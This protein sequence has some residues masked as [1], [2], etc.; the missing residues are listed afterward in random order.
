MVDYTENFGLSKLSSGEGL[1]A[2]PGRF[3]STDRD[4]IDQALYSALTHRHTGL[5]SDLTEP[6]TAPDLTLST[7]GGT[8]PAATT[9]RYKYTYVDPEFGETAPSPEAT[10]TTADPLDA[11][12]APTASQQ[13]IGGTLSPGSY[14]Y[15]LTHYQGSDTVETKALSPVQVIVPAGTSTN[16]ITLTLPTIDAEADGFNLYRRSPNQ[17]RYYHLATLPVTATPPTEYVDDGT[18]ADNC[19]R[20]LPPTNTTNSTN[21]ITVAIPGATPAI[22]AGYQ[23]KLYRTYV[24]GDYSDSF[25]VQQDE[26]DLDYLDD[27]DAANAGAPPSVSALGTSPEKVL[28]TGGAEVQGLLPASMVDVNDQATPWS[29]LEGDNLEEVL[30]WIDSNWGVGSGGVAVYEVN[31]ARDDS[32]AEYQATADYIC[33]GTADEVQFQAAVDAVLASLNAPGVGSGADGAIVFNLAPG[34]YVFD[35]SIVMLQSGAPH[36]ASVHMRGPKQE[37]VYYNQGG[38]TYDTLIDV[39]GSSALF[40]IVHNVGP[41]LSFENVQIFTSSTV[42][43]DSVL[44][45]PAAADYYF[46]CIFKRC[47]LDGDLQATTP[48]ITGNMDFKME[49]CEAF[50]ED[51]TFANSTNRWTLAHVRDC[52]VNAYGSAAFFA[53]DGSN[54]PSFGTGFDPSDTYDLFV[55]ENNFFDCSGSTAAAIALSNN[56]ANVRIANNTFYSEAGNEV[57]VQADTCWNLWMTNNQ[58]NFSGVFLDSCQDT[59]IKDNVFLGSYHN[60]I[61]LTDCNTIQASGNIIVDASAAAADTYSG[62]RLDGSS[63]DNRI[64]GNQILARDFQTLY[65]IVINDSSCLSNVVRDN[66]L[67]LNGAATP[68]PLTILDNGTGSILR[69]AVGEISGFPQVIPFAFADMSAQ[70]NIFAYTVE[71]PTLELLGVRA[72]VTTAPT[73]DAVIVDVLVYDP[74]AATPAW[75]S[76]FSGTFPTI[77]TSEEV[78][79]RVVPVTTTLTEGMR[80]RVDITQE[81]SGATAE[82][83]LVNVYG[84]A[85]YT[86]LDPADFS[87]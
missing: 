32:P 42:T 79:D 47:R 70:E 75:A 44:V 68:V 65:G 62:I 21:S 59:H 66:V 28:L 14:Y 86:S 19:D 55:I 48:F 85:Q 35:D 33:D 2:S 84:V 77:A 17:T 16:E 15:V 5:D 41:L 31:M 26:N 34:W 56:A 50:N 12:A 30:S 11:P 7:T 87:E 54:K 82:G 37:G 22:P 46:A 80:L 71:V 73:T 81:D 24:A 4:T 64:T 40:N 29:E 43:D 57:A 39:N 45:Q 27:G 83:L 38:T 51:A 72:N 6:D 18:I 1:H 67:G 52:Y 9:V 23:W 69:Y 58:F 20:T 60:G 74:N 53:Y 49:D 36:I 13:S 63:S 8:I 25:I 3:A 78:S 61:H 10:V 76:I